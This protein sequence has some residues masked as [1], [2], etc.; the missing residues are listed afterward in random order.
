M[1]GAP[2]K[3]DAHT[4]MQALSPAAESALVD[5]IQRCAARGF[6]LNPA[7]VRDF[8]QV[9]ARRSSSS[10]TAP[11]LGRAWMQGFLLWHPKLQ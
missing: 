9:L 5:H 1:K 11:K 8:E 10:S 7:D 4:G 6:P 3:K 2:A